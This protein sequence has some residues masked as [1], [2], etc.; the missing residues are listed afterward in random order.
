MLAR[1]AKVYKDTPMLLGRN[2]KEL[3]G[4]PADLANTELAF[5]ITLCV[6]VAQLNVIIY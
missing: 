4:I 3:N 2:I 6:L 1:A 5:I